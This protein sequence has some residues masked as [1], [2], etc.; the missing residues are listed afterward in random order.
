MKLLLSDATIAKHESEAKAQGKS[1]EE[2]LEG[3]ALFNANQRSVEFRDEKID[4]D[5]G[6]LQVRD[7]SNSWITLRFIR[8]DDVW[9]ID[10]QG[11]ANLIE[12]EIFNRQNKAFGE[13]Q[14]KMGMETE[15]VTDSEQLPQE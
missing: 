4:G 1:L 12:R 15:P 9:K 14:P 10:K 13:E 11:Q 5:T 6:T 8:E 2:I 7:A 3:D